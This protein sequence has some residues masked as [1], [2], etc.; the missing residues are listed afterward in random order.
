MSLKPVA[1]YVNEAFKEG[2]IMID[3]LEAVSSIIDNVEN[4]E[5]TTANI[6]AGA[7]HVTRGLAT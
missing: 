7:T 3:S 5:K 4:Q 6:E 1:K 2:K